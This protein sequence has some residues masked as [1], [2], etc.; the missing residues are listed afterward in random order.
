MIVKNDR[1]VIERCLA[2]VKPIISYWVIVDTGSTDGTQDA[3]R[4]YLRDIPGELIERP[5]VDFAHNRSEALVYARGM[6]DYLLIIDADEILAFAEEFRWPELE[7]DGY[8]IETRFGGLSYHRLQL[9]RNTNDWYYNGIVHEYITSSCSKDVALLNDVINLPSPDGARS[10]DPHKFKRDALALE[11]ALLEEPTNSRYVFY[12]AQ[13]YREAGECDNALKYYRRRVQMGGD[14][15]EVWYSLYQAASMQALLGEP[16]ER[17]LPAL[18]DAYAYRPQRAEPLYRIAVHYLE[19]KS[20]PLA[21]LFVQQARKIP[22]PGDGIFVERSVYEY[23]IAFGYAICCYWSGRH[24]EAIRV[25]NQVLATP[26]IAPEIFDR[27]LKN[28]R[29]SLD[30]VYP[31][32]AVPPSRTNR[33]KVLVSFRN[34]GTAFDNCIAS[35][36]EQDHGD[37]E[38]IFIDN[39]STDESSRRVPTDDPRVRLIRSQHERLRLSLIHAAITQHCQHDDIVVI[40]DGADWLAHREV[41]SKVNYWYNIYDCSVLYGQYGEANGRYGTAQPY[42]DEIA[43]RELD[44]CRF[45]H[46]LQTFRARLYFDVHGQEPESVLI[47]DRSAMPAPNAAQEAPEDNPGS[48]GGITSLQATLSLQGVSSWKDPGRHRKDL[49]QLDDD[50]LM[51]PLLRRAGLDKVRFNDEVMYILN[52]DQDP[53]KQRCSV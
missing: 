32:E 29:C 36:L 48:T 17:V 18:L 31:K 15:E 5:W 50:V 2:S 45:P 34:P 35:L 33:F 12:L 52:T 53:T 24:P 42:A 23:L 11:G 43:L 20:F 30:A 9:V 16:W 22:Y 51:V 47:K 28:R 40:V 8:R 3:I 41:L 38:L 4:S 25:N 27:A 7:R 39:A 44:R 10:A 14:A 21:E 1:H 49:L 19:Q 26:G 13:S 46:L 6:A 37:F